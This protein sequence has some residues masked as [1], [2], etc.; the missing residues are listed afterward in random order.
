MKVDKKIKLLRRAMK[1][2]KID[3]YIIPT[4][5]PHMSEYLASFWQA[6]EWLSGFTGS[7]GTLVITLKDAGLWTDGRYY[8]QAEDELKGSSIRLFKSGLEGVPSFTNWLIDELEEGSTVGIDGKLFSFAAARLLEE[9][10]SNND[11]KL[12]KS[13]DLFDEIWEDR[14]AL[15]DSKVFL[16]D[17]EYAG[18]DA[19]QKLEEVRGKMRE[20]NVN[21]HIVSTLDDIAWLFNIRGH[22]VAYNPVVISYALVGLD[23]AT[24]FLDR[25]KLSGDL[26]ASLRASGVDL[27]DYEMISGHLEELG[28]GDRIL[29]D[30]NK[31]NVWLYDLIGKKA[32][33]LGA[34][35]ISIP[36]KARKNNIEIE[37]TK[38]AHIR[39]GVAMVN[40][41]YWLD[42]NLDKEYIDELTISDKL[43][44]FRSRGENYVYPSFPT[45]A[46][47]KDHGAIVH[48]SASKE[49]AYQIDREGMLLIDSGCQYLDGT[50][51][52]TRTL[53]LGELTEEER[54]DYTL[55]L[56]GHI[57]LARARFLKGT[58]GASLDILAR[59]FLWSEGFDYKHG[60]GHGIGH[61]LNVHEGPQGISQLASR[62]GLE[63]GMVISNEPGMYRPGSHGVR[64]EN[65]LL[66]VAYKDTEFGEFLE[67]ETITYCPIDTKALVLDLISADEKDW[68]NSYHKMVYEKLETNLDNP[69]RSWLKDR[70][71]AL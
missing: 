70:T 15:P 3:A 54:L 31:T 64:I 30:P 11:M 35:T 17:I 21:Y 41:L 20:L 24:L 46:G 5:D 47:Y 53:C 36:L 32:F 38:K 27:E 1:K 68:I 14:P 59:Q 4:S 69:V 45:I 16:H 49:T 44:E 62:V 71:R 8:L 66:V 7:A 10:L 63:E 26:E 23:R 55:T 50:T 52:I 25:D 43:I 34:E 19:S 61:F 9:S 2:N 39:D 13:L 65:E 12:N 37:S 33:R 67:F 57:A 6:R 18:K 56:K 42:F 40:F 22:D 58:K 48:Y 29:Y 28:E 60:T 51:D